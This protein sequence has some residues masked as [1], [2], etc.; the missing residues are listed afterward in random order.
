MANNKE[1]RRVKLKMRIR[2]RISGCATRPRLTVFRSNSEIYAQL[3]D[4][5]KGVTLVSASSM[6]KAFNKT[7]SK[8]EIA[9]SV[10]KLVAERALSIGIDSVVFDRNGYLYHG[11]VKSLADSAREGGLKF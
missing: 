2:K 10:G 9:I 1:I 3:I 4:D 8:T 7:G 11:R 5:V 6:E